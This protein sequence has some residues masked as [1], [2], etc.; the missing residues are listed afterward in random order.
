MQ[1]ISLFILIL[2]FLLSSGALGGDYGC[3]PWQWYLTQCFSEQAE[4]VLNGL[5]NPERFIFGL[6]YAAQ[7]DYVS[8]HDLF[9][10][11]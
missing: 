4:L 9:L 2:N 3:P 11:S 1:T 7:S 10:F 6:L 8:N 5:K